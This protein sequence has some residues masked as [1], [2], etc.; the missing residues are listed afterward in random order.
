MT[1]ASVWYNKAT[2]AKEGFELASS[3]LNGPGARS[4][5]P[6]AIDF[7]FIEGEYPQVIGKGKGFEIILSFYD[8]QVSIELRLK[9]MLKPLRGKIIDALTDE[10]KRVL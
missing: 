4:K 8:Q 9:L 3:F 5:F 1:D 6:V 2:S 7:S 10:I